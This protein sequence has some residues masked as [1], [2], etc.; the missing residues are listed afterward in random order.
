MDRSARETL[1]FPPFDL[2]ERVGH[3]VGDD[4]VDFYDRTGS[5]QRTVIE[6]MLPDN[7]S[8]SRR[9]VLDFGCGA[10][11]VLRHFAPEAAD[12]EF[13]GCDIDGP[14]IEWL[15][16]NLCPPF[17]AQLCSESPSLSQPDGYFDLIYAISVFTHISDNWAGWLL[18]LHRLLA[19]GGLLLATFLGEGMVDQLFGE[20]WNEEDIGMNALRAG[21][22]WDLGGP[23]ILHSPWWIQAHWGR[24]FEIVAMRPLTDK[25]EAGGHGLVLLR[26]KS[27][28]LTVQ[29]I[30]RLEPNEPRELSALQHHVDQLRR[31]T[32]ELRRNSEYL[33]QQLDAAAA[34]R[35]VQ[36]QQL[37]DELSRS[38]DSLEAIQGSV[39]WRLTSPL[40]TAKG[41]LNHRKSKT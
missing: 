15:T 32:L 20:T 11:R 34:E 17:N 36:I 1:P 8:W 3:L 30:E 41:V 22:P 31:E 10:G 9:R 6:S 26:R 21:N 12:G 39:S 25:E 5:R 28:H 33:E 18:E 40:R 19:E 38:N 37:Q 2:L 13:W 7:W 16:E 24:A 4:P 29:D 35:G 27:V 14:S 23:T